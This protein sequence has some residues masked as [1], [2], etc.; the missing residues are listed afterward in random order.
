MI[1]LLEKFLEKH[2]KWLLVFLFAVVIVPFVFTIGAVP[3]FGRGKN[4]SARHFFGLNLDSP[5][6]MEATQKSTAMSLWLQQ[7]SNLPFEQAFFAR[8]IWLAMANGF[9][10]PD[11]T[12]SQLKEF[13]RS[14]P[15]FLDGGHFS[16]KAYA[17]FRQRAETVLAARTL[18][19]DWKI[20]LVAANFSAAQFSTMAATLLQWR[21]LNSEW[22]LDVA[23]LP[24]KNF[25]PEIEIGDQDLRKFFQ[26]HQK[27]FQSPETVQLMG[28][29]FPGLAEPMAEPSEEELQQFFAENEALW[30]DAKKDPNFL[31]SHR[32]E[33]RRSFGKVQRQRQA[34]KTASDFAYALYDEGVSQSDEDAILN[35]AQQMGGQMELIAPFSLKNIPSY[36]DLPPDVLKHAF[37]LSE[38][39]F[40]SDPLPV[41]G[42]AVVLVLHQ[43]MPSATPN[44]EA[45]ES[46]VREQFRTHERL[47]LFVERARKL[48][49]ELE[50]NPK[51]FCTTA[52]NLGFIVASEPNFKLK[53]RPETIRSEYLKAF[54]GLQDDGISQFVDEGPDLVLLHIGHRHMPADRPPEKELQDLHNKLSAYASQRAIQEIL[55]TLIGS[56]LGKI[57]GR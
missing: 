3:S 55:N 11:P 23:R 20:S 49:A 32:D 41:N 57:S 18:N 16:D 4:H 24:F 51:S 25:R 37:S 56:E 6:E 7:Q 38:D 19:E 14:L 52:K 21:L 53:D 54:I 43:R 28:V 39:N 29:Y 35:R 33:V 47:R 44:F 17:D 36:R 10:I 48:R 22:Q 34:L 8:Q 2:S 12:E 31:Q 50:A 15:A 42:G 13:I 9:Q 30:P 1:T 5:R 46:A 27:L 26:D 45:V 40:F